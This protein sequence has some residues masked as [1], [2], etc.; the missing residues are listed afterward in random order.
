MRLHIN[1]SVMHVH[2]LIV[3][4]ISPLSSFTLIKTPDLGLPETGLA[5]RP[6]MEISLARLGVQVPRNF[7]AEQTSPRKAARRYTAIHK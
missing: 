4:V 5:K 7:Y 1:E 2:M 6:Q 3:G